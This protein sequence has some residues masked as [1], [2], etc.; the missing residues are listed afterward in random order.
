MKNLAVVL[1]IFLTTISYAQETS[2][3]KEQVLKEVKLKDFGVSISID[4]A[5]E[6]ESTFTIA[7]IRE[8]LGELNVNED[9]S[10]E[11]VCNGDK[12]SN[13][14]TTTLTYKVNG[15]TSDIDSFLKSVNKIRNA[16]INYYSNK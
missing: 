11:V 6:L 16:A 10:F 7:D 9:V 5:E 12:M 14:K 15:N 2:V 1:G 3:D 4:S 8:I 13:G